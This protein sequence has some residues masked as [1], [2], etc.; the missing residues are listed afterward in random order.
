MKLEIILFAVLEEA[1]GE[2]FSILAA[3]PTWLKHV[4]ILD[5]SVGSEEAKITSLTITALD[6]L[7][8]LAYYVSTDKWRLEALEKNETDPKQLTSDWWKTRYFELAVHSI[9]ALTG[10][11]TQEKSFFRVVFLFTF[12]ERPI[13]MRTNN[14]FHNFCPKIVLTSR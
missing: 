7:P 8:R 5:E 9:F 2:L 3:S 4:G 13:P 11:T 1:V 10:W 14:R 12:L 6:V